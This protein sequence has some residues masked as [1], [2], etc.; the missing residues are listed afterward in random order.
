MARIPKPS[1][2]AVVWATAVGLEDRHTGYL[3]TGITAQGRDSLHRSEVIIDSLSLLL[4]SSW[5]VLTVSFTEPK[6]LPTPTTTAITN[7]EYFNP[8]SVARYCRGVT[9]RGIEPS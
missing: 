4:P 8:H 5:I 7:S 3:V 6:P 1:W 2:G 9:A